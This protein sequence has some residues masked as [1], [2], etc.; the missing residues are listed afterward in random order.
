MGNSST[1][2]NRLNLFLIFILLKAP[3]L[4]NRSFYFFNLFSLSRR[5]RAHEIPTLVDSELYPQPLL[6]PQTLSSIMF[7]LNHVLLSYSFPPFLSLSHKALKLFLPPFL[8]A[9]HSC[10]TSIWS[11][12]IMWS[13]LPLAHL[14][15]IWG[16]DRVCE[17]LSFNFVNSPSAAF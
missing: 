15:S 7:W 14:T 13:S 1:G 12:N 16:E 6:F 2:R 8:F 9:F 3:M 4:Q 17:Y 10:S 11:M 5:S